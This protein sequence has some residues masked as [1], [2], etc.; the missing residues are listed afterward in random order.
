MMVWSKLRAFRAVPSRFLSTAVLGTSK[1]PLIAL[2]SLTGQL[3]PFPLSPSPLK[4][5]VC[6]PTV[7]DSAH[8][9]HARSYVSQDILRRIVTKHFHQDIFLVMGMTDVDDKI[10]A[11]AAATNQPMDAIA[12]AH[13]SAFLRDL[14]AL[15]VLRVSSITRVSE[16]IPDII[17]YIQGL[18]ANGFAYAT[19]D[20][21]YFDTVAL[22]D[23]YGKLA[24]STAQDY[25][26]IV[27]A[28]D[29]DDAAAAAI[30]G[31]K[32]NV[33]DFALWKLSKTP[34]EPG[35]SSPWGRGRPGWHIECSA[36]THHV[37]GG[38][39]DVHSGG[40][41]LRFPH[42]NNEIAQCDG[43]HHHVPGHTWCR[44]FVH[45]G[46]LYIKG[47]KMSKSLKN[48]ITID[49]LLRTYSADA[50]RLFCLQYKYNINVH[51]S[52][53]RMRDANTVYQRIQTFLQTVQS[54]VK[55]REVDPHASKRMDES[56]RA[57]LAT[58]DQCKHGVDA[59][60]RRDFD[61]PDALQHVLELVTATN[62][63]WKERGDAMPSE[64]VCAVATY[65]MDV[66]SLF[67][68][69]S[70]GAFPAIRLSASVD[71][72]AAAS[73][74]H[75][76]EV[77]DVFAQFRAQ[78]RQ[79][80]LT[81]TS[82]KVAQGILK[83]CDDVRDHALPPVGIQLEDVGPGKSFWKHQ[84]EGTAANGG[85][86]VD[87]KEAIKA[88]LAAKAAEF[89]AEMQIAPAVFFKASSQFDGKFSAFDDVGIPTH[90]EDGVE[91]TKSTRKKLTKKLEKHTKSYDKFWS[92]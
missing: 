17:N 3:D 75:G 43:Y 65:V 18:E 15:N 30:G 61:T 82:D 88:A 45:F 33:R 86:A 34:E 85:D 40:V 13:E 79:L 78:V 56:D 28:A 72:A 42:H 52:E 25:Q 29:D 35:W 89:E 50:F 67:G 37:L 9:G 83:L 12:R 57:L 84:Q 5:Y 20:G 49:A 60:L 64:V 87:E 53:D 22:G 74:V 10:I 4:W 81:N 46:H 48:F 51:F 38:A 77:M 62:K 55:A 47:L 14:A 31:E 59:A 39:I 11:A 71:T 66:F 41:D 8:L 26:D 63:A 68:V 6:G 76:D 7:Y 70:L 16:H 80:A 73:A 36:M 58:L 91:L 32:R 90:D 2:N 19:A 69:D 24:P 21:V 92:K 54:Y 44:H 1:A 23:A 27:V